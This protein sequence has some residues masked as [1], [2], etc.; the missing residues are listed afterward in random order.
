[1]KRYPLKIL[2]TLALLSAGCES[3]IEITQAGDATTLAAKRFGLVI[4]TQP[5]DQPFSESIK[6]SVDAT[7]VDNSSLNYQWQVSH[8]DGNSFTDV[9]GANASA[10]DIVGA[11]VDVIGFR[12]RAQLWSTKASIKVL[13]S[14]AEIKAISNSDEISLKIATHPLAQ[15]ASGGAAVFQATVETKNISDVAYQWQVSIDAGAT[16]SD[17]VGATESTISLS[18]LTSAESGRLYRLK[19]SSAKNNLSVFSDPAALTLDEVINI[20]QQPTS[21]STNT[22]SASFAVTASA[23][24]SATLAYQWQVSTNGGTTFSDIAGATSSTLTLTGLTPANSG[25]VYK[26]KVQ[27]SSGSG[28]P[29]DSSHATLTVTPQIQITTQPQNVTSSDGNATF[30]IVST[31][32]VGTLTYQWQKSTDGGSSFSDIPGKTSASLALTGLTSAEHN[33]RYR[34]NLGVTGSA[35]QSTSSSATLSMTP[36]VSITQQPTSQTTNTSSVSFAVTASATLSAG[37][38]YQWQVSSDSGSTFTDVAGA[39]SSSLSLS[40]L[41]PA[42]S[43]QI[44]KVRVQ[45]A[46]GAS[47]PVFSDNVTLTVTPLLDITNHP[48]NSTSLNGNVTFTVIATASVGTLTYQWQK[49]T[50]GGLSFANLAGKTS[51]S[52]S[53]SSLTVA[54]HDA[55]F[56]VKIGALNAVVTL[57]SSAATLQ[58]KPVITITE[59][60]VSQTITSLSANFSVIATV[61]LGGVASYQWQISHDNGSTFS[62]ISGAISS[63]LALSNLAPTTVVK[64][65]RVRITSSGIADAV[66]SGEASLT[67]SYTGA[68]SSAFYINSNLASTLDVNG[69]GDYGT[70]HYSAY[71]SLYEG[72]DPNNGLTYQSGIVLHGLANG[73]CY[74]N[75]V[76]GDSL[77]DP[78]L[79]ITGYCNNLYYYQGNL[80]NG[81][82]AI[83]TSLLMNMESMADNSPNPKTINPSGSVSIST[84]EA[85]YGSSSLDIPS[86]SY[87]GLAIDSGGHFDFGSGNWTVEFWIKGKGN[88]ESCARI[89]QTGNGDVFTGLAIGNQNCDSNLNLGISLWDGSS[90]NWTQT[91]S[92]GY[93][94]TSN[95]THFAVVRYGDSI[96]GFVNGYLSMA[97][98]FTGSLAPSSWPAVIGGNVNWT[99]PSRS[100]NAYLDDIRIVKGIALYTTSFTP[101]ASALTAVGLA[102]PKCFNQGVDTGSLDAAGTG[103]CSGQYYY[104]GSLAS[105]IV[106][107]VLYDS[108]GYPFQGINNA[109]GDRYYTNGVRAHG[110]L[111]VY[112]PPQSWGMGTYF[113]EGLATN[114]DYSGNGRWCESVTTGYEVCNNYVEGQVFN[115]GWSIVRQTYYLSSYSTTLGSSGNGYWCDSMTMNP[116]GLPCG[117]Y[118]NGSYV[119]NGWVGDPSN[120]YL[121]DGQVVPLDSNGNG[122]WCP[123]WTW[124]NGNYQYV[125]GYFEAG[126]YLSNG[127]ST[128]G[129]VY[130]VNGYSSSLNQY[131]DGYWC[132]SMYGQYCGYYANGSPFTN[133]W[134][135]SIS[136]YIIGTS[137]TG[138]DSGGNGTWCGPDHRYSSGMDWS[139]QNSPL[140]GTCHSYIMG[141]V[142]MG[143]TDTGATNYN[144][145]ATYSENCQY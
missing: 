37:V 116:G 10:L 85:L 55:R 76:A 61:N 79:G 29:V 56:R 137:D 66:D 4:K 8:D 73:Y 132:D 75:G 21:Q 119:T 51:A 47:T 126:A 107:G 105:G 46:S 68:F 98:T 43:G 42:N 110:Y 71:P 97:A 136:K 138:L 129:N 141:D 63:T 53:L 108:S 70:F 14:S 89:F 60:P 91:N 130:V 36:T 103:I 90:P 33:T 94:D 87:D 128:Y 20:I 16:F 31:A 88:P 64:K 5:I 49:S 38:I 133:G 124:L 144:P 28:T 57:A 81:L 92:I 123:G 109:D 82:I 122:S 96:M 44:Y 120:V 106:N 32:S 113:I 134:I 1:M 41:T 19:A 72:L 99:G 62:N 39:T 30:S 121:I 50:D 74:T 15:K 114:L 115:D 69:Y 27:L 13:S 23:T 78:Y 9:E 45:A 58:I 22:S 84:Q 131:G 35:V 83:S 127:W 59:Q 104:A 142:V 12:Y 24:P 6:F 93:Y 118:S 18:N 11:T 65:Y 54:D 26:V 3:N 7:S 17:I 135:A 2:L 100:I 111:Y 48:E 86:G 40:G 102:S 112:A 34:V 80:A 25:Q 140:G 143:C 125:C 117:Y 139:Y 52:L 101:P 77:N 67:I 145:Q 95:W